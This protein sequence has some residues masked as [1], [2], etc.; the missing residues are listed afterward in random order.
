MEDKK[1]IVTVKNIKNLKKAKNIKIFVSK[2]L[3]MSWWRVIIKPQCWKELTL[4][5]KRSALYPPSTWDECVELIKK[6]EKYCGKVGYD[7]VAQDFGLTN[8][9]TKS[10]T[11]RLSAAKQ[12]GLILTAGKTLQNTD[13]ARQ[14]LYPTD[15]LAQS[16][17]KAECFQ[18]PPLYSK[19]VERFNGKQLP[20]ESMLSNILMR[21]YEIVKAVKDAAAKCFLKNAEQM[22]VAINGVLNCNI[23]QE[24]VMATDSTSTFSEDVVAVSQEPE[25]NT[26]PVPEAKENPKTQLPNKDFIEQSYETESGKL[27]RI[28]I[29]KDATVDDLAAIS[30]ML[31]ILIK[32]RFKTEIK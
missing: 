14:Y 9:A 11:R 12:F 18:L 21:D 26:T 30:D 8:A 2:P 5:E 31:S 25:I 1:A 4:M 20:S 19:L 32:R 15:E 27:A 17:I 3:T 22:G 13:L 7:A 28:I 6:I 16:R 10:F 24:D 23:T 29:P